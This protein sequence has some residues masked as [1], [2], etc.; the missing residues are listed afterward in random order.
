MPI[1]INNNAL[2]NVEKKDVKEFLKGLIKR[3]QGTFSTQDYEQLMSALEDIS[4]S[5]YDYVRELTIYLTA[6]TKYLKLKTNRHFFETGEKRLLG[7]LRYFVE[8]HDVIE[9]YIAERGFLDD[10]Y[11]V[12]YAISKQSP[13]NKKK[14]EH[15]A[16][17]LK[18]N[19]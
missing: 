17:Y 1:D 11:C 10:I 4:E 12:N 5:R 8:V 14:I 19:R 2:T 3:H 6:I 7:A 15:I 18:M 13:N 9:D 16:N